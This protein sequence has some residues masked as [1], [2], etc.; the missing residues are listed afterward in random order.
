[1]SSDRY[2][3]IKKHINKNKHANPI[4]VLIYV[5][6]LLIA[7]VT[8]TMELNWISHLS[9]TLHLWWL[10]LMVNLTQSD[11]WKETINEGLSGWGWPLAMSVQ[12]CPDYINDPERA[13]IKWTAPF[14]GKRRE[15]TEC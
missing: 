9:E 10:I 6:M 3:H 2:M 7:I 5:N 15:H 14:R 12:D 8:H 4:A 1:M 13:C 11:T